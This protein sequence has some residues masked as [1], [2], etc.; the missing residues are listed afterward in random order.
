MVILFFIVFYLIY[1]MY[2]VDFVNHYIK[3]N[4]I[5]SNIFNTEF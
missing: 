5:F 3:K 4:Y 1:Y 2:C